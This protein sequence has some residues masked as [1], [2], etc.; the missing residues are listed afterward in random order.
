MRG[1]ASRLQ[2]QHAWVCVPADEG[3]AL[4]PDVAWHARAVRACACVLWLDE[5][6]IVIRSSVFGVK[7][8][9]VTVRH[10]VAVL[11]SLAWARRCGMADLRPAANFFLCISSDLFM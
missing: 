4:G 7:Y 2:H 5:W 10:G 6:V 8:M 3:H 1:V 9:Y 11:V